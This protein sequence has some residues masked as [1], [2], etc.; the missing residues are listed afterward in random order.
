M[1]PP[2]KSLGIAAGVGGILLL[3]QLARQRRLPRLRVVPE[4]IKQVDI[5]GTPAAKS[6]MCRSAQEDWNRL[7]RE[8]IRAL[9]QYDILQW[10]NRN[11]DQLDLTKPLREYIE[12]QDSSILEAVAHTSIEEV[13]VRLRAIQQQLMGL[14]RILVEGCG[15]SILEI[16]LFVATK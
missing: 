8:Y 10:V 9:Q 4:E 2:R 7:T 6:S 11:R 5:T 14:R 13:A 3:V 15:L 12:V 16:P 1:I